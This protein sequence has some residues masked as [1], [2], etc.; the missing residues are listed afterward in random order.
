VF[1]LSTFQNIAVHDSGGSGP[2][3][4]Y[5]RGLGA[6]AAYGIFLKRVFPQHRLIIPELPGHGKSKKSEKDFDLY[7]FTKVLP[8]LLNNFGVH[9]PIL[10]GHSMGG[11]IGLLYDLMF[12]GNL[13][14]MILISPAGLETF[15]EM[16]KQMILNT[17]MLTGNFQAMF[18][19]DVFSEEIETYHGHPDFSTMLAGIQTMLNRPVNDLLN[20]V[21][22][23]VEVI[24]G[25]SDPLIPNRF[26]N[27]ANTS[28]F[29]SRIIE[30]FPNFMLHS[31][32]NCGHWPMVENLSA[33]LKVMQGIVEKRNKV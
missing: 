29:I 22:A 12:P 1:Q 20:R 10:C 16:Q 2:A 32:D 8:E 23:P 25:K 14:Y 5:L 15:S 11:Q 24:F 27:P 28:D 19:A 30:P 31:L 6:N 3:V 33:L 17:W 26:F 13:Q 7:D 21:T 4:V 18:A 9:Q